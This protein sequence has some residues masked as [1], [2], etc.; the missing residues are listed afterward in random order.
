MRSGV[1]PPARSAHPVNRLVPETSPLRAPGAGGR[2]RRHRD[3]A[4]PASEHRHRV[5]PR[6][7]GRHRDGTACL[8]ETTRR[9]PGLVRVAG[10]R[11]S[12]G[13]PSSWLGPRSPRQR[14]RPMDERGTDPVPD[15]RRTRPGTRDDHPPGRAAFALPPARSAHDSPRGGRFDR[16]PARERSGSPS[17]RS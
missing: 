9:R 16:G 6:L 14:H 7:L 12:R 3:S 5:F 2:G 10:L 8:A 11:R 4:R 15:T 1:F 17:T 13:R